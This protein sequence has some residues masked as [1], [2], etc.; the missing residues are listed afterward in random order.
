MFES[1][2]SAPPDAILGLTEAFRNETNPRK[3][4]LTVGVF[5]DEA[6]LTPIP[7][8]VKAAE[9][10]ILTGEKSKGYL[11]IDGEPDFCRLTQEL[12][13]GVEHEV[14][15]SSRATVAQAPGGTGALRVAADF[16]KQ[17]L[18]GVTVWCS[19]P[20]WPNHPK[21][22]QAA[23]LGVKSYPY[24]HAATQ[25]IDLDGM[26]GA[27][28]TMTPGDVICLHACCHNPT[29]ADPQAEQW[30]RIADAVYER[31]L[32]P[33]LD[34]A[35][36]GFGT[37]LNEDAI[38]LREFARPGA[39][40]FVASSYSKNFGLYSE[41]VGAL[42]TVAKSAE[43]ARTVASQIRAAIRTNY[44]NPPAHGAAIIRTILADQDLKTQWEA[45]LAAMRDRINGMRTLLTDG[46][47]RRVAG[48]DFSYISR[49]RGMFSYSGLT[50]PQV[51]ALKERF[52]IYCV[53]DGRINVAGL[54][55]SNVDYVC[56]GIAA[57]LQ[58]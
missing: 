31:G 12:Y 36:L 28:R 29:G 20:T 19:T 1:I 7:A 33:L 52:G 2:Q 10:R 4:N 34:F 13:F 38:A 40:L 51:A 58:G 48:R 30:K 21:I 53:G 27:I 41:R 45:E 6:G 42:I 32:L 46:L 57:V 24:F 47:T 22:F 39:E 54:A 35:Y 37:G 16:L 43:T 8:C 18:G 9:Q 55:Q 5:K 23:G 3:V 14:V 17:N 49:Q 11:P 26:L 15:S 25:G 44:S 56:D 50:G